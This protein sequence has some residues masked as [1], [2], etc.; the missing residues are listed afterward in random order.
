MHEENTEKSNCS[1]VRDGVVQIFMKQKH[2]GPSLKVQNHRALSPK[3]LRSES[4]HQN[5]KL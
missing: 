1:N 4:T 2:D 5:S 3:N